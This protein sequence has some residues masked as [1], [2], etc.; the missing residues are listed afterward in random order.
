MKDHEANETMK[1]SGMLTRLFQ[2]VGKH[3]GYFVLGTLMVAFLSAQQ[4]AQTQNDVQD[5]PTDDVP[6]FV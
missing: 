6:L 4:A 1:G 2:W 3:P 5:S